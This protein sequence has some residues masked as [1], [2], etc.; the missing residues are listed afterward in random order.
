MQNHLNILKNSLCL[1]QGFYPQN[2]SLLRYKYTHLG[3]IY[4]NTIYTLEFC[5]PLLRYNDH[6]LTWLLES[7]RPTPSSPTR[8]KLC[9]RL[10]Y[11]FA[12]CSGLLRFVL[13]RR[14]RR[15]AN[16]VPTISAFMENEPIFL[17]AKPLCSM[18]ATP[19]K[20]LF[21]WRICLNEEEAFLI[22]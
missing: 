4:G 22:N 18:K 15:C 1:E 17:L 21:G 6:S 9:L 16:L 13:N 19:R 12:G 7:L 3:F 5:C 2:V 11:Y 20:S 14:S 8:P 10:F